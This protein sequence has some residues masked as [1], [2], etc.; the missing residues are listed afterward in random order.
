MLRY[1]FPHYYNCVLSLGR[2]LIFGWLGREAAKALLL[3]VLARSVLRLLPNQVMPL[4]GLQVRTALK[5]RLVWSWG[6]RVAAALSA[7][8]SGGAPQ[9]CL[10]AEPNIC[11]RVSCR[12]ANDEVCCKPA[13]PGKLPSQW[14][15]SS[16][17]FKRFCRG[18]GVQ[19]P[20]VQRPPS[21][22][23]FD[24]VC[25]FASTSCSLPRPPFFLQPH[26]PVNEYS[27]WD[28]SAAAAEL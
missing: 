1:W 8:A 7:C 17:S 10:H 24:S 15:L 6:C 12:L 5:K 2:Y 27:G 16:Q 20:A 28:Y 14:W 4:S 22:Y 19:P 23:R 26:P 18:S 9:A 25:C 21:T 3:V 13:V 11:T